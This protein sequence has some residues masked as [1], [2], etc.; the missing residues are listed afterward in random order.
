MFGTEHN[1]PGWAFHARMMPPAYPISR[2]E[3][4]RLRHERTDRDAPAAADDWEAEMAVPKL[5]LVQ[6]TGLRMSG[7]QS[8]VRLDGPPSEDR[9]QGVALGH[10]KYGAF[11]GPRNLAS[12]PSERSDDEPAFQLSLL[13]PFELMG[14]G[15]AIDLGSKKLCGLVALLACA[16]V[17]QPREKLMSLL[18]GS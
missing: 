14:P 4:Q 18:W 16:P 9:A 12:V 3:G 1:G 11:D 13:G 5:K 15:G 6:T 7:K 17:A 2:P 10:G 8:G